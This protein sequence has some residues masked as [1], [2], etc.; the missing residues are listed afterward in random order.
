MGFKLIIPNTAQGEP[1]VLGGAVMWVD[2]A[3][4]H[5]MHV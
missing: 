3:R 2:E 5:S 4:A 1:D